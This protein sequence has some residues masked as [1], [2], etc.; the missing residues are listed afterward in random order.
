MFSTI[1]NT[2][3][4]QPLLNLLIL[5]Y[6]W[7]GSDVG[8]AI[9]AMTIII[10]LI[11]YPS[12]K[13]QLQSQKKLADMQ[14]KLQDIKEKF[15]NDKEAQSKALMDFYKENKV[16]PFGSCLPLIIQLVILIGLFQVLQLGLHGNAI[17]QLYSFISNPG[18]IS[19]RSL[20]LIDLAKPNIYLAV[21]TGILQFIQSRQMIAAQPKSKNQ[22]SDMSQ[23][24]SRQMMYFLPVMTV[25]FG[26][27]LPA[28]LT[29]YWLVTT[30]FSIGQQYFILK[31]TP[32]K[33]ELSQ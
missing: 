21:I 15:K 24:V 22:S 6:N 1:Y 11:L 28:G 7:L 9:I 23:A 19:T 20:G 18:K 31:S 10:R 16:N 14:P 25:F 2:A 4:F 27:T 12:Y 5:L 13:H 29:L 32:P 30:V 17:E 3:I 8:L 26:S 33:A